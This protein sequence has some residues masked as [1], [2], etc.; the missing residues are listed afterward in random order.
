VPER[1]GLRVRVLEDGAVEIVDPD[2]TTLEFIWSLDPDFRVRAAPLPGFVRPRLLATKARRTGVAATDLASLVTEDLWHVHD[3]ALG[4]E[5]L[6]DDGEASLLD[7]KEELARRM[8]TRCELCA[9]RCRVNRVRGERGRCG[10][11]VEASIYEAYV[12]IAEEPPINPAFNIS[13][14][15]CGMRCRYCQ[16]FEALKPCG[17]PEDALTPG[18]WGRIDLAE[19]RSLVFIGGNPTESLPAVLTFLRAVPDDFALPIGWNSSAFDA[20]EAI[21]LL[22]GI[23]DV[24][25]PDFKYGDDRCAAMLSGAPGYVE[26]AQ[27]VVLEMCRQAVP[28]YVRLL[29]V[30]GHVDCCHLPSLERLAPVRSRIRL[31]VMGQYAPDFLVREGEGPLG[32]RPSAHEVERVRAAARD[33]GFALL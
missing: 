31:N 25:I 5:R 17:P 29:V 24:Y 28:V 1:Q 18:L 19:A 13:L 22:A 26:N 20:P 6:A 21:R 12:H 15:G 11:G 8:L 23:C 27:A 32:W 30:P 33:A 16:Q 14:R 7:L 3:Q 2:P 9:H 10:L 4:S